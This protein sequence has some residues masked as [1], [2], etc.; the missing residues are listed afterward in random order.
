VVSFTPRSLYP[1]ERPPGNHWIEGWVDPRTGLTAVEGR[2]ILPLPGLELRPLGRPVRS[3]SLSRFSP[4]NCKTYEIIKMNYEAGF[5]C[6]NTYDFTLMYDF[7]FRK[8][9]HYPFV[10][11]LMERHKST[12]LSSAHLSKYDLMLSHVHGL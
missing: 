5:S 8:L 2:K 11:R 12:G 9:L 4:M 6:L 1:W 3:Q 7:L 10:S